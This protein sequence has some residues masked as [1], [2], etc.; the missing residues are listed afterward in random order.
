M[1][2][3]T[4]TPAGRRR[5][6]EA[7]VPYLLRSRDV[8]AE[9]R[10]WVNTRNPQDLAYLHGLVDQYPDFFRLV[11]EPIDPQL[12][13][14]EQIW[15]YMRSCDEAETVY[16][17]LDDDICYIDDGAIQRLYERR[18]ADREPFL[19]LGLIVNNAICSHFYQQAGVLPTSW[20][21]VGQDCM[22]EVGWKNPH[23][24]RRVH[25][26]FLADLRAGDIGR[27]RG[28]ETA[29]DGVRRF[30]VNAICWRGEDMGLVDDRWRDDVDEELF[31]TDDLPRRFNRPNVIC[32]EALFGHYAFFT[33][34]KFLEGVAPEILDAYRRIAVAAD[35]TQATP[36]SPVEASR[37]AVR[38]NQGRLYW[39]ARAVVHGAKNLLKRVDPVAPAVESA[40][41]ATETRNAA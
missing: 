13:I 23:F 6:L 10:W 19:V 37:L 36:P 25:R 29:F 20:G 27:W 18:V 1:R 28:L 34:R 3:V 15:R 9:H 11:V 30:S 4:V 38:R 8:I 12:R 33:Q 41:E 2:L 35:P 22:D 21:V 39:N 26:A 17:R 14:G 40:D 32:S 5:Y 24:A 7:L 16:V 31:V